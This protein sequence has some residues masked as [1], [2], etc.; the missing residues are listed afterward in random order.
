MLF[1]LLIL[2]GFQAELS[3]LTVLRRRDYFRQVLH[4]FDPQR[5]ANFSDEDILRCERGEVSIE[6]LAKA[7]KSEPSA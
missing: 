1:E 4:G 7:E 5:L 6:D 2:E 3:W